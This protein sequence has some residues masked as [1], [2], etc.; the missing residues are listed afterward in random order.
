MSPQTGMAVAGFVFIALML[1]VLGIDLV[2]EYR[3][4]RP[5]GAWVAGWAKRYPLFA[6][7][8]AL[9][10]GALTGHLFWP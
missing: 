7:G 4:E 6:A 8:L 2:L 1:S 3:R 5:L 9:V 10:F